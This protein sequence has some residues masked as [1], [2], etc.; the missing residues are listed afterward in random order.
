MLQTDNS[1]LVTKKC[2]FVY[3]K[4]VYNALNIKLHVTTDMNYKSVICSFNGYNS[5]R[6][7]MK[8]VVGNCKF[9]LWI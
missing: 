1:T 8:F 4:Y 6:N 9:T 7:C 5:N 2:D 3:W